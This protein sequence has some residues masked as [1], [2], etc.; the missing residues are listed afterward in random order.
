MGTNKPPDSDGFWSVVQAA[1]Q[2]RAA[3]KGLPNT[4]YKS[5]DEMFYNDSANI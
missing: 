3:Q 5:S 2:T 1:H 4:V